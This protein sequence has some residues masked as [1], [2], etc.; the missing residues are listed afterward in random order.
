M[1]FETMRKWIGFIDMS[2]LLQERVYWLKIIITL[3]NDFAEKV[4]FESS[5]YSSKGQKAF[6]INIAR[7]VDSR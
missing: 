4:K 1:D 7:A 6:W 5:W 2:N 3:G